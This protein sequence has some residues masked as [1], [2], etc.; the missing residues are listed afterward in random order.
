MCVARLVFLLV[1]LVWLRWL[2][3]ASCVYVRACV[4]LW[5]GVM[6][7]CIKYI[8]GPDKHEII[9]HPTFRQE[10]ETYPLMLFP[11]IKVQSVP[12]CVGLVASVWCSLDLLL[13]VPFGRL[14]RF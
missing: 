12:R 7:A 10:L 8:L 5:V 4:R 3:P 6:Q 11:I 1:A 14:H 9:D 2:L 13:L